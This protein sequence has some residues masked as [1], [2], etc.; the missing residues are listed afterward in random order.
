[1][2]MGVKISYNSPQ[3]DCRV[4]ST[5]VNQLIAHIG[6]F[7]HMVKVGQTIAHVLIQQ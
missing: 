5:H 7:E 1:M 4:H 3:S 2:Q 6:G